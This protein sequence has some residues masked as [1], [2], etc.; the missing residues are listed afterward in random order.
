[1]LVVPT[2]TAEYNAYARSRGGGTASS[3]A[4][5]RAALLPVTRVGQ[6]ALVDGSV[7]LIGTTSITYRTG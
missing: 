5:D 4:I 1:M 6:A 7:I 2:S 3:L